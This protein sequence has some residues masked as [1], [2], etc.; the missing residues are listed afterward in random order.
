LN[1][2][3]QIETKRNYHFNN[4]GVFCETVVLSENHF[5]LKAPQVDLFSGFTQSSISLQVKAYNILSEN[6]N[7]Y[8]NQHKLFLPVSV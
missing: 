8:E 4:P 1:K 2:L 7:L 5:F 6:K 3:E